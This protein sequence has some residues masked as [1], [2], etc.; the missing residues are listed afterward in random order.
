MGKIRFI[1]SRS[2]I[3]PTSKEFPLVQVV[4]THNSKQWLLENVPECVN[5][6]HPVAILDAH[7]CMYLSSGQIS[8]NPLPLMYVCEWLSRMRDS[9]NDWMFGE[10]NCVHSRIPGNTNTHCL[11][12]RPSD[13]KG[14][15]VS[16]CTYNNTVS[17]LRSPPTPCVWQR[18]PRLPRHRELLS[19]TVSRSV[20]V[21]EV[22][23][24]GLQK[25]LDEWD[26][27]IC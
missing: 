19:V 3:F 13:K 11:I 14:S 25:A 7:A 17:S 5:S 1:Y 4:K 24:P 12:W 15:S 26:S 10:S 21:L 9:Q 18:H 22:W 20:W 6:A 27:V 2:Y 16:H 23:H 8:M